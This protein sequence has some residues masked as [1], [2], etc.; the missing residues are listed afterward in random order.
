MIGSRCCWSLFVS[1]TLSTALPWSF[2]SIYLYDIWWL[3]VLSDLHFSV[4]HDKNRGPARQ[5]KTFTGN[6]L[7]RYGHW[8][9]PVTRFFR[10]RMLTRYDWCSSFVGFKLALSWIEDSAQDSIMLQPLTWCPTERAYI[11]IWSTTANA[12][13]RSDA[14]VVSTTPYVWNHGTPA[15]QESTR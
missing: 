12:W 6:I 4:C 14:N 13:G 5:T 9:R 3:L 1:E 7:C 11:C 2:P 10:W 15:I 8:W